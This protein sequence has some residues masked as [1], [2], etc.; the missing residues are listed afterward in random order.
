MRMLSGSPWGSSTQLGV[1]ENPSSK[2]LMSSMESYHAFSTQKNVMATKMAVKPQ[3]RWGSPPRSFDENSRQARHLGFEEKRDGIGCDQGES[4]APSSG[5]AKMDSPKDAGDARAQR[6]FSPRHIPAAGLVGTADFQPERQTQPVGLHVCE[7]GVRLEK[8]KRQ[9][10]DRTAFS[11]EAVALMRD[12]HAVETGP[13]THEGSLPLTDT[14]PHLGAAEGRGDGPAA[15]LREEDT[16]FIALQRFAPLYELAIQE[17]IFECERRVANAPSASQLAQRRQLRGRNNHTL[18][19]STLSF[20]STSTISATQSASGSTAAFDGHSHPPAA[21]SSRNGVPLAD[22]RLLLDALETPLRCK[23]TAPLVLVSAIAYLSRVTA[24]CSSDYLS[25]TTA[26]WFRL[27][28]VAIL[29]ASKMYNEM[30]SRH[31][32]RLLATATGTPLHVL[33]KLEV[34]FLYLTDFDLLLSEED[35]EGWVVWME[36]LA[37]RHGMRTPYERF[38]LGDCRNSPASFPHVGGG[39]SST[40]ALSASFSLP[41]YHPDRTS[42]L[43]GVPYPLSILQATDPGYAQAGLANT[44]VTGGLSSPQQTTRTGISVTFTQQM[45][46]P[47]LSSSCLTRKTLPHGGSWGRLQSQIL[48]SPVSGIFSIEGSRERLFTVVHA[49]AESITPRTLRELSQLDSRPVDTQPEPPALS[50]DS[51]IGFF[52]RL[53]A[54]SRGPSAVGTHR[55]LY[56]D[57]PCSQRGCT[58]G[59]CQPHSGERCRGA[60]LGDTEGPVPT[61]AVHSDP[62]AADA[63]LNANQSNSRRTAV[64]TAATASSSAVADVGRWR[65]LGIMG[66]VRE[67]LDVTTSLVR[68]QL[69]V[70][71]RK[72]QSNAEDESSEEAEDVTTCSR[73][74]LTDGCPQHSANPVQSTVSI[75]NL[76]TTRTMEAPLH[77]APTPLTDTTATVP[78]PLPRGGLSFQQTPQKDPVSVD[79]AIGDEGA[80][81]EGYCDEEGNYYYYDDDEGYYDP[82]GNYCYYDEDDRA[83]GTDYEEEEYDQPTPCRPPPRTHSPPAL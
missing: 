11:C 17:I 43:A 60:P 56:S 49:P 28:T 44:P 2:S 14:C 53:A 25:V 32:N 73:S 77:P 71:G 12:R 36:A 7:S 9:L 38:M 55:S 31:L 46:S 82:E 50:P 58:M 75:S 68:G 8:S 83:D 78:L 29:V 66:R 40:V 48:P 20:E 34:D 80:E 4:P 72:E 3:P 59:H 19:V 16:T 81:D 15:L 21:S 22:V 74:P 61:Y 63:S 45:P 42:S 79:R 47:S 23:E 33:N 26:N 64:V 37:R 52:K 76:D 10:P 18:N 41:S 67:V 27:T 39:D 6:T 54:F 1:S 70:M 51:P 69:H 65:R 30:G 62:L 5:A 57:A 24:R 13:C 35:V